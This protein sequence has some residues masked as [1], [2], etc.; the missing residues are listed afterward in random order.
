MSQEVENL[1]SEMNQKITNFQYPS[2]HKFMITL[3]W[4]LGFVEGE[5]ESPWSSSPR[6]SGSRPRASFYLQKKSP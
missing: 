5:G 2:D 6:T 3:Y 4:F 1:I